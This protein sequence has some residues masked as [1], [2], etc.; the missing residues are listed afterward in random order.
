ME[1]YLMEKEIHSLTITI[2]LPRVY[3]DTQ[4]SVLIAAP[5][6]T[7]LLIHT[8]WWICSAHSLTGS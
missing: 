7:N 8:E 1:H 3:S 2:C 6:S 4:I 5:S